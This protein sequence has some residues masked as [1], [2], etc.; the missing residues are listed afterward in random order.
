MTNEDRVHLIESNIG[1]IS[2][3][4]GRKF[5]G[6]PPIVDVKSIHMHGSIGASFAFVALDFVEIEI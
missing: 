3:S 1:C 6:M 4:C 5:D 2:S